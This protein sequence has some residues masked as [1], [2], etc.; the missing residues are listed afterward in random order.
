VQPSAD[1]HP[2]PPQ[3]PGKS[4]GA[5]GYTRVSTEDQEEQ[6]VSLQFQRTLLEAYG[7]AVGGE[8]AALL[9]DTLSGKNMDRP[10]LRR[11]LAML[12]G[13]EADTLVV[14]K[15]DRLTRN[16]RD[17][18]ELLERYFTRFAL[19]SLGD[20]GSIDTRTATGRFV[21]RL[22][23][24][25]GQLERER[26]AERTKQTLAHKRATGGGGTPRVEA[27]PAVDRMRELV[28]GGASLREVARRLN[29]EG[30]PTL[31]GGRWAAQ[32]VRKILAR[33]GAVAA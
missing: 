12:E 22:L 25:L 31:K 11:A 33:V 28:A 16:I 7:A 19:V 15:L 5:V 13:G 2:F 18:E 3:K 20:G 26:T 23:I 9:T 30:V 8:L 21:F 6:G 32:T 14:A 24:I 4:K 29:A 1:G 10:G 27:G 17:A